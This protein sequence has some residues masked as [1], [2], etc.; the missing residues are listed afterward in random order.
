L[1]AK[2][3]TADKCHETIKRVIQYIRPSEVSLNDSAVSVYTRLLFFFVDVFCFFSTDLGGFKQIA[4]HVAA[5]LEKGSSSNLSHYTYPRVI[6]VSDKIPPGTEIE[7]ET[8]KVF[9]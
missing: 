7:K 8:R 5:W 1:R 9:L 4:C 3:A 6:I 2:S